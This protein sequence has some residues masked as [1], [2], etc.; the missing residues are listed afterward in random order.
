MRVALIIQ[1]FFVVVLSVNAKANKNDKGKGKG[2]G[3]D[4]TPSPAPVECEEGTMQVVKVCGNEKC[5]LKWCRRVRPC[6]K[7]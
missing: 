7:N 5:N 3:G 1:L 6:L 4:P 2:N